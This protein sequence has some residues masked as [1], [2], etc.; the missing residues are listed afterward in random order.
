MAIAAIPLLYHTTGLAF[1]QLLLLVFGASLCNTPGDTARGALLPDLAEAAGAP[2][3]RVN[4]FAQAISRGTRLSGAPLAGL[5]I[6]SLGA[7]AALWVDAATFLMSA[8]I[9]LALVRSPRHHGSSSADR[10]VTRVAAGLRFIAGSRLILTLVIVV[11]VTN[12]LDAPLAVVLPVYAERVFGSAAAL[13]LMTA[14]MG[15]GSLAGAVLYGTIGPRLRRRSLFHGG[16]IASAFPLALL[17]LMPALP[18]AVLLQTARG[19]SSAPLNPVLNTVFQE[20][21]P[22][23]LRGRVLGAITAIAWLTMPAGMLAGGVLI[24]QLGLRPLLLILGGAY[25]LT[26]VAM[27]CLPVL[28]EMDEARAAAPAVV[29][30][31]VARA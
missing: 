18:V 27:L 16:F 11:G 15:A 10:Y 14:G 24:E 9:V 13:G 3:E 12:L 21:V 2:L 17:A 6:V 25:L 31:V 30:G 28:R 7:D 19:V 1:R 29:G 20:R 4:A 5:L 22:A 26:T 23:E 8:L